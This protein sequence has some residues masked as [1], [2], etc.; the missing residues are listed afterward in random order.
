MEDN[1]MSIDASGSDF[2]PFESE[3]D[4]LFQ[5]NVMPSHT[6][7]A[8]RERREKIPV[9]S[10]QSHGRGR[11]RARARVTNRVWVPPRRASPSHSALANP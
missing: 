4:R 5:I 7:A 1:V 8:G 6:S 3:S 9:N 11:G 2:D 10:Q